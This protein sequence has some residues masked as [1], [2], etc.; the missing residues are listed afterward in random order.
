LPVEEAGRNLVGDEQQVRV[1][2]GVAE[3]RAL[4]REVGEGY[5]A[6][7]EE[8]LLC[9]VLEACRRWSGERVQVVEV[10]GH[11]REE[12]SRQ[13]DVTRTVGWFTTKYPVVVELSE[14]GAVVESLKRVK[15][16][17]RG[18]PGRGIGYG[19]LRYLSERAEVRAGLQRGEVWQL[20]FNYLGQVDGGGAEEEQFELEQR[21]GAGERA[22]ENARPR[23]LNVRGYVLAGR[24]RVE[25]LTSRRQYREAT[26]RRVADEFQ[27]V[28]QEL[29]E[30]CGTIDGFTPSDF[31]GANISQDELE[32]FLLKIN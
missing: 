14:S 32:K 31:P 3:T 20:S 24:L 9:A 4:Q 7:V 19:L 13:V 22:A 12:L 28:L 5:R 29:I 11:G 21:R 6:Q 2:L 26:I 15:E 23:E 17:L 25:W 16:A 10:E 1:E 8:V 18:V 30:K 27:A